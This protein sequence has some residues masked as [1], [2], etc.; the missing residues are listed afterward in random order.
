M[1]SSV[2]PKVVPDTQPGGGLVTALSGLNNLNQNISEN[3][4]K[5][6]Q[7]QYAP[8]TT[9]ADAASKLAYAN[10]LPYQVRATVMSNPMLWMALKDN[11]NAINAMM[12]SFM[13]SV[14]KGNNVFGNINL[15]SPGSMGGMGVAG[16]GLLGLILNKIG[17]VLPQNAINNEPV[18]N[19][20][21]NAMNQSP[22]QNNQQTSP[23]VPS[24]SGGMAGVVGKNIA[25]YIQSPYGEGKAIPD[26]NNPGQVIYTPTGTTITEDQRAI[27]A[28]QR[29]EPQLRELADA[30]KPFMTASGLG[31]MGMQSL[32]NFFAG[33]KGEKPSQ[34]AN[35]KSIVAAAPEALV[36]AYGLRPTNETINRMQRVI[37]PHLGENPDSYHDR[38]LNEL[39]KIQNEQIGISKQNLYSGFSTAPQ[40][41]VSETN[42]PKETKDLITLEGGLRVP[43]SFASKLDFQN[44]YRSQPKST[45]LAYTNY[46]KGNE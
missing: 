46:L 39:Q 20:T 25:P 26:P 45:Q 24:A 18:S 1:F 27:N 17:S 38:V 4:I 33:G 14:P 36:K 11:P 31:S 37:E 35:Y 40:K 19:A 6:A 42:E 13:Q 21:N 15:P 23:L 30:A 10:M 29:V 22:I 7:A 16:N 5:Q 12:N 28:A 44:W 41:S 43:K 9:Y 3:A 2:L 34:Y 32:E 8:Y